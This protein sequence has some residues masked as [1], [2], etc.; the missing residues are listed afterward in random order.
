MCTHKAWSVDP[1]LPL[2]LLPSYSP[3]IESKKFNDSSTW[4]LSF[5]ICIGLM[6]GSILPAMAGETLP[7]LMRSAFPSGDLKILMASSMA[8]AISNT[9]S[10]GVPILAFS[11]SSSCPASQEEPLLAQFLLGDWTRGWVAARGRGGGNLDYNH[12]CARSFHKLILQS[13]PCLRVFALHQCACV[14]WP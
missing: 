1:E 6:L 3:V 2:P 11:S 4:V 8:L 7:I 9:L 14:H 5:Q 10:R 13:P 12:A